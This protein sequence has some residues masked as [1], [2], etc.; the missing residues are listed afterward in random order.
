MERDF[1]DIVGLCNKLLLFPVSITVPGSEVLML[2]WKPVATLLG[3][4]PE[5]RTI[6]IQVELQRDRKEPGDT[7]EPQY[8][9]H[10]ECCRSHS[11]GEKFEY[12]SE[13]VQ[14]SPDWF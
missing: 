7:L 10:G 13:P 4:K 6:C 12:I 5:F 11:V 14:D 9:L 8:V 3:G 1:F 2:A